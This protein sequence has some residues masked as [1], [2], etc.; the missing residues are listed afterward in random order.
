MK[1]KI[2][3]AE[4]GLTHSEPIYAVEC[5]SSINEQN[6]LMAFHIESL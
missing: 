4:E 1:A 5:C 2:D 3:G 6:F